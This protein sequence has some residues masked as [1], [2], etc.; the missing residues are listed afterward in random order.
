[1][2]AGDFVYY[3]NFLVALGNKEVDLDTDTFT[4]LLCTSSYTPD[5]AA[6]V[7]I[8]DVTNE[9][10]GGDYA[11]VDLTSVSKTLTGTALKWTSAT[12]SFGNPVTLTAKYMLIFDNTHA[13][14]ILVGY[15]DLN[16]GGGSVSSTTGPFT[17]APDG[18]LGWL[19]FDEP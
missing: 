5:R 7:D 6:H 13:S 12:V 8:G 15:I 2:A 10:S 3:N 19:T 17:V 9:L 1:M 11:R 18:T 4:A 14:D 16:T